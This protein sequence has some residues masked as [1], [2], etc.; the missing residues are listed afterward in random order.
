MQTIEQTVAE[1]ITPVLDSLGISLWGIKV[2]RNPKHAVL[3]I[4]IDK[5]GG[6]T[7][8]DCSDVTLQINGVLDVADL[9]KNPYTLEVSSP[10][11]DRLLFTFEQ[12]QSYIGSEMNIEVS[13]PI[14]NRRRFRG[15]LQKIEGDT[16]FLLVDNEVYEIAYPNVSKAQ[17]IPVF[18]TVGKK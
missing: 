2:V 4:F 5:D 12:V 10:G 17:L 6:V 18:N 15:I 16:L 13:M 11:L 9:F 8:D 1:V 7:I 14:L 3:Q